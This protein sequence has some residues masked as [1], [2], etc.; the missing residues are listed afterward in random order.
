MEGVCV[1]VVCFVTVSFWR[2]CV[3]ILMSA[4]GRKVNAN[5]YIYI[6]IHIYTYIYRYIYIYMHA[7]IHTHTH[8]HTHTQ[9]KHVVRLPELKHVV[10]KACRTSDVCLN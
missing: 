8:T 6:Y 4:G 9:L 7:Y 5:L 3:L 2:A 10:T 1:C